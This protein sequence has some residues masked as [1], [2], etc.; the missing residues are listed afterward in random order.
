MDSLPNSHL[1]ALL[2]GLRPAEVRVV[3]E[4]GADDAYVLVRRDSGGAVELSF[5]TSLD[6][7]VRYHNEH[8]PYAFTVREA[9]ALDTGTRHH[10]IAAPD[11][12]D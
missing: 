4:S 8:D 2:D 3:G 9:L 11:P 12:I 1:D 6:A 10:P 5:H 7:A